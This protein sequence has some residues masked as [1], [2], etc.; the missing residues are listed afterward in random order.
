MDELILDARQKQVVEEFARRIAV[1]QSVSYVAIT[2]KGD[3]PAKFSTGGYKEPGP[4]VSDMARALGVLCADLV[5]VVMRSG[6]VNGMD[7]DGVLQSIFDAV[8]DGAEDARSMP[9]KIKICEVDQP[10]D[11][12]ASRTGPGAAPRGF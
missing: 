1:S 8:A 6:S 9:G 2:K 4:T 7:E 10:H 11:G 5:A 3:E 12:G